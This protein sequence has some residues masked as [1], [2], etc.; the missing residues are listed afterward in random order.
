MLAKWPV[1]EGQWNLSLKY[2][3]SVQSKDIYKQFKWIDKYFIHE[4]RGGNAIQRNLWAITPWFGSTSQTFSWKRR[5]RAIGGK[6]VNDIGIAHRCIPVPTSGAFLMDTVT[7][8]YTFVWIGIG[9]ALDHIMPDQITRTLG[10][11]SRIIVTLCVIYPLS[12]S[13]RCPVGQYPTGQHVMRVK[14]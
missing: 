13:Q 4:M 10:Y 5:G 2:S 7:R 9:L 12:T 1:R 8:L 6:R 11:I 3:W 14:C